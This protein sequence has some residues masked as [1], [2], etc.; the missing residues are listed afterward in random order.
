M[1]DHPAIKRLEDDLEIAEQALLESGRV[2]ASFVIM[3]P[4][5]RLMV[6]M[7]AENPREKAIY[8]GLLRLLCHAE[9][10]FAIT[11]IA[12]CWMRC[13]GFRGQETVEELAERAKKIRPSQAPDRLEAIIAATCYRGE[14]RKIMIAI[15]A[16][17]IVRGTDGRPTGTKPPSFPEDALPYD[18]ALAQLLPP[19]LFSEEQQLA[20]RRELAIAQG[21]TGIFL[22]PAEIKN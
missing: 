12:E 1:T 2:M 5:K 7:P 17:E 13:E 11:Q 16:R 22:R 14:D 6:A 20:A 8:Y 15:G 3:T 21:T 4:R 9:N 18:S 19:A 10:A